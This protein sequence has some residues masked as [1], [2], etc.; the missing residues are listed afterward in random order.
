MY[1]TKKQLQTIRKVLN[2]DKEEFS[3]RVI[4]AESSLYHVSKGIL[5]NEA[6]CEDVVQDA[7][8][9]AF[10]KRDSLKDIDY[11]KTWLIRI[12]I[13]ECYQ[14]LRTKKPEVSYDDY[15]S[16]ETTERIQ[17][18]EL[19][20]AIKKLDMKHRMPIIL[21]YIEG[22][23]VKDIAKMLKIPS[24]TV[25]SRLS[26]GRKQIKELLGEEEYYYEASI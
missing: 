21:S 25:K 22:Y 20:E 26:K 2:M 13:N 12:L 24:G 18:M 11:F 7:I 15:M 3:K 9:K 8:L 14:F 17:Y 6:D 5:I 4:E 1:S 10:I 16:E 19:Y 23:S